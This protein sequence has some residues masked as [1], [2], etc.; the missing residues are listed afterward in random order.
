VLVL[1]C[2]YEEVLERGQVLEFFDRVFDGQEGYVHVALFK[3]GQ[4]AS[5]KFVKWP[6]R[7]KAFGNFSEAA[8]NGDLY[9]CPA[10][11]SEPRLAKDAIVS[12]AVTWA[13]VDRRAAQEPSAGLLVASGSPGHVHAYWPS[14]SLMDVELTERWNY[15][16]VLECQADAGGWDAT[17]LLRVP[18]TLNH[19]TQPPRPVELLK[20][21]DQKFEPPEELHRLIV[22]RYKRPDIIPNYETVLEG[23]ELEQPIKDLIQQDR[24][25][26]RSD[27]MFRLGCL[28]F[29][30]GDNFTEAYSILLRVDDKW[31]KF[32]GRADRDRRLEQLIERA[33]SRVLALMGPVEALNSGTKDLL[34]PNVPGNIN[35][36]L[37]LVGFQSLA[38]NLP[39]I[40][41]LVDHIIKPGGMVMVA[42]QP[43]VGK[44][45]L[46]LDLSMRLVLGK[47]DWAG[48]K[49]DTRNNK[50]RIMYLILEMAQPDVKY[51]TDKMSYLLDEEALETLEQNLLFHCTLDNFKLDL[52]VSHALSARGSVEKALEEGSFTGLVIDSLGATTSKGLIDDIAV[53][54]TMDWLK[55]LRSRFGV[56]IFILAH[57]RKLSRDSRKGIPTLDDIFG[58]QIQQADLDA[59]FALTKV[60][61]QEGYID[62]FSLKSRFGPDKKPLRL[63]RSQHLLLEKSSQE[64]KLP[65]NARGSDAPSLLDD[66]HEGMGWI[67]DE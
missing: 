56:W 57:A 3:N 48:Y 20:V 18:G 9:F 65:T 55:S 45:Q 36:S 44:S 61:G 27:A 30:N 25:A 24:P 31:G 16:H 6:D 21:T 32:K 35:R 26:D 42:S 34:Q 46:A 22:P 19:K 62:L 50:Q 49:I 59:A 51:F 4:P 38:K 63:V 29:E 10:V 14:A 17:Q 39:P 12:S 11:L 15:W 52:E 37:E 54:N 23:R 28:L 64:V 2:V 53:R 40:H 67:E 47:D 41:W 5:R 13:D 58:S 60:D 33:Y 43:G 66:S 1:P 7:R 8:N